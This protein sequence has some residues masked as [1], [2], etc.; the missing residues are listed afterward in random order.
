M[1]VYVAVRVRKRINLLKKA[2]YSFKEYSTL[3]AVQSTSIPIFFVHGKKDDFVP[4]VNSEKNY[5]ACPTEKSFFV[6]EEAGHGLSFIYDQDRC[7]E[8]MRI[9]FGKYS[10]PIF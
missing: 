4:F 5:A 8:E 9:F 2:G 10:G 1:N 6:S 7:I 3:D